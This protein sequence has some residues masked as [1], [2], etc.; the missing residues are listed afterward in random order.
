MR[1]HPIRHRKHT[2]AFRCTIGSNIQQIPCQSLYNI[3]YILRQRC[4]CSFRKG[5]RQGTRRMFNCPNLTHLTDVYFSHHPAHPMSEIL[6]VHHPG[7]C[8]TFN[9]DCSFIRPVP[10][11]KAIRMESPH[12]TSAAPCTKRVALGEPATPSAA[13]SGLSRSGFR[14]PRQ[15]RSRRRRLLLTVGQDR[16]VPKPIGRVIHPVRWW[17]RACSR[18]HRRADL[19][20]AVAM[21]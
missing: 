3:S 2:G 1:T 8:N 17:C 12:F 10:P 21:Q 20:S 6:N 19:Q 9:A 11:E 14:I 5:L 18:R 7:P 15:H 4:K 16:P 13:P